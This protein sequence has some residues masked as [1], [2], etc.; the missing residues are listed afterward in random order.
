MDGWMECGGD[1]AGNDLVGATNRV[2]EKQRLTRETFD[3][4]R[5]TILGDLE[6]SAH[7]IWS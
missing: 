4:R 6:V 2:C 1:D 5:A 3:G 7:L